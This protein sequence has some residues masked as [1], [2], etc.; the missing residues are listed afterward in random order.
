MVVGSNTRLEVAMSESAA[1][2]VAMRG[3]NGSLV[4]LAAICLI[5]SFVL[6]LRATDG[7]SS[8]AAAP[9]VE[10]P[11]PAGSGVAMGRD[12]QVQLRYHRMKVAERG[13]GE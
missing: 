13:A 8:R 7:E 2:A 10:A 12:P 1:H 11:L 9:A 3:R 5:V 6:I 4:A